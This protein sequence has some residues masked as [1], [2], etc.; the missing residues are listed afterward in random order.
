[1]TAGIARAQAAWLRLRPNTRG[2]IWLFLCGALFACADGLA[3][4]F[5]RQGFDVFEIAFVRYLLGL[6]FVVPVVAAAGWPSLATRR[7]ALH[8]TRATMV[9]ISQVLAYYALAHMYV[10]DVTAIN[11]VRPLFIAL[12]AVVF[13]GEQVDARRWIATAIGFGGVVVMARPGGGIGSAALAAVASTALLG[14][15]MVSVARYA[16]TETP[17]RFVFYYHAGG[18]L[19]FLAP[20]YFVWRAPSAAQW[21]LFLALA[22]FSVLAQTCA[23]RAYAVG[24]AS[25]VGPV[26]Y[27]RLIFAALIGYALFGEVPGAATWI[28]AA[29]IVASALYVARRGRFGA[30]K[31]RQP[32]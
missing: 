31:V 25:V 27:L 5:T 16:D 15:A 17:L 19:V 29:I 6:V 1:V 32:G 9:A 24:E 2:A 7:P 28:G 3:K 12:L 4:L 18:A 10:A 13:L 30:R 26:D 23:V 22:L 11:F 20:V 14:A 21:A 8:A